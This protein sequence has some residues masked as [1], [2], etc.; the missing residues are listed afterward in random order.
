LQSASFT[1]SN[2]SDIHEPPAVQVRYASIDALQR[3]YE[4]NLIK[5][6][7]FVEGYLAADER[8]QVR[9]VFVRPGEDETFECWGEVIGIN[10]DGA[11]RGTGVKLAQLTHAER[12][13]LHRFASAAPRLSQ[14]PAAAHSDVAPGLGVFEPDKV[15]RSGSLSERV[16]LERRFGSSVWQGLLQNPELTA[17]E[18]ARIAQNTTL[19][20]PLL[21]AIVSN[22]AWLAKPEVRHAL[23]ANSAV[24]GPLLERVVQALPLG[25]CEQVARSR[26][27][28]QK[29]RLAAKR[30]LK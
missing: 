8:S 30:R 23:L 6:R 20:K 5:G 18:V 11:V 1:I 15:A 10:R 4:E 28:R 29:V 25:E 17:P 13:A 22:T 24:D 19:S 16:A 27:F 12:R 26:A 21:D 9:L 2:V 3:D 7:V 14:Q